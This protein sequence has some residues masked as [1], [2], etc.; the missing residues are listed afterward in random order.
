MDF[1]P[2]KH[3]SAKRKSCRFSIFPAGTKSVVNVGHFLVAPTLPPGFVDHGPKL[4]V[5][6]KAIGDWPEMA[7]IRPRDRKTS[8]RAAERPPTGK[9]KLSRV[10]PGYGNIGDL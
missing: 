9:P 1:W 2:K 3:F 4:R 5:L 10:T 6:I 8:R 7:K